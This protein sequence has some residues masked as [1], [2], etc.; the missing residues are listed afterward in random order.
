MGK[1]IVM[2][3]L[4]AFAAA[5]TQAVTLNNPSFEDPLVSGTNNVAGIVD[6][7]DSGGYI[8]TAPE[9]GE[10]TPDTPYGSNW[11]ELGNERW[12]YQQI[13]TYQEN[14]NY[15]ISFLLG[16]KSDKSFQG[17]HGSAR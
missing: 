7:F 3:C 15:E 12:L 9:A 2:L 8:Y 6:W 14:V 4:A 17:I 16:Q 13:G 1:K 5:G 10:K 11:A